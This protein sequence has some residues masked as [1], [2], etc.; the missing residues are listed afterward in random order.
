MLIDV[1]KI[2]AV[3]VSTLDAELLSQ[4]LKTDPS[5]TVH[6]ISTCNNYPD[7]TDL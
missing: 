5:L 6:L 2:P 3:A 7:T 4:W 1:N